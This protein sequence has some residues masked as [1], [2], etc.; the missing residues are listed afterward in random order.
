MAQIGIIRVKKL[1]DALIAFVKEDYETKLAGGIPEESF[2]LR[3]FDEEDVIDGIS[4]STLAVEI[5][6]RDNLE[7]RK[8][9]TRLMFD[10][11]RAELPTIH[12]R[13]P[14]KNKGQ[15]DGV[16]YID[17]DLYENADGGFNPARRRSFTSQ[18]ELMIT[19][20]NRHDVIIIEE[21]ILAL[22]IGAQDTLALAN[23]FYNFSFNVKELIANNELIPNPLF[24]KSIGVNVSYDKTYP[25][26]STNNMLNQILFVANIIS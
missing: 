17:D 22:L 6:T 23:P 25:D 4:Y 14:A 13:E 10:R 3:C 19:S 1:I 18:Y 26:L 20:L 21:V 8:L 2:L 5:F 15:Q 16:G 9:E 24:I 11:D 12:V 7:R